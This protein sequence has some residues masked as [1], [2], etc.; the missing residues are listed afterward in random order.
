MQDK[1]EM[2]RSRGYEISHDNNLKRDTMISMVK[3]LTKFS[4]GQWPLDEKIN[5]ILEELAFFAS[6]NEFQNAL[7]ALNRL[8]SQI[9][10]FS[11]EQEFF[12][13]LKKETEYSVINTPQVAYFFLLMNEVIKK[14]NKLIAAGSE[15]DKNLDDLLLP[16]CFLSNSKKG[17]KALTTL[18][19]PH[20]VDRGFQSEFNNDVAKLDSLFNIFRSYKE[21]WR[22]DRYFYRFANNLPSWDSLYIESFHDIFN[23]IADEDYINNILNN[24]QQRLK[25]CKE[26]SFP[27]F[28]HYN[29]ADVGALFLKINRYLGGDN[30][31]Q[32]K[33]E[34]Q[35]ASGAKM[36]SFNEEC[37]RAGSKTLLLGGTY[38]N[39]CVL[40]AAQKL[41][42]TIF[43][44]TNG[45]FQASNPHCRWVNYH[46]KP[47]LHENS[48]I[49]PQITEGFNPY[50]AQQNVEKTG[51]SEF[52]A[53]LLVSH[54]YGGNFLS[55]E[56]K[57]VRVLS[58]LPREQQRKLILSECVD[59][60]KLA[61]V[62]PSAL[63]RIRRQ[64]A[65]QNTQSPQWP[66]LSWMHN[67]SR[68]KVTLKKH[69]ED[70]AKKDLSSTRNMT[71]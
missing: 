49:D 71:P 38:G 18:L 23:D 9:K 6:I 5:I 31:I 45:Y 27:A 19:P 64:N 24:I 10:R 1:E 14:Q 2:S 16:F 63:S 57:Q 60:S 3:E 65:Q 37:R 30:L 68:P 42:K 62:K 69:R 21:C 67:G 26:H 34:E 4:R 7:F 36:R 70:N 48:L 15:E 47:Y 55:S 22:N 8:A 61:T 35:I 50:D 28:I 51:F 59:Y 56:L 53:L 46:K 43:T 40:A 13:F 54:R 44:K 17:L 12:E 29:T 32:K 25:I 58:S 11:D 52:P 39:G 20:T 33:I 66:I 41:G